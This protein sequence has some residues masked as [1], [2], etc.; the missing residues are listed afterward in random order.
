MVG[1]LA[2]IAAHECLPQND[3]IR[4][5]WR[6]VTYEGFAENIILA[7]GLSFNNPQTV[8]LSLLKQLEQLLFRFLLSLTNFTLSPF[9]ME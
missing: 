2:V 9:L 7:D 3:E 1:L 8:C 4:M 6:E 5:K